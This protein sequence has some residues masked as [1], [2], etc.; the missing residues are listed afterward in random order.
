MLSVT[1]FQNYIIPMYNFTFPAWSIPGESECA[2]VNI[3]DDS[4]VGNT[5]QIIVGLHSEDP[6]LYIDKDYQFTDIIIAED[7]QDCKS[8]K[9]KTCY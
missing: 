9:L 3:I 8:I 1:E 4:I 6:A 5:E 2:T 7:A